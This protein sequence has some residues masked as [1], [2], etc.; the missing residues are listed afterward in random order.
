[1]REGHAPGP[2]GPREYDHC[3]E[4]EKAQQS[5]QALEGGSGPHPD[6]SHSQPTFLASGARTT[7]WAATAVPIDL[8]HT[9]GSVGTGRGLALINICKESGCILR[10]V[11]PTWGP[12][13]GR[14]GEGR[15]KVVPQAT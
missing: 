9:R 4:K 15:R 11:H 13:C 2:A 8:I 14:D 12:V 10:G 6:H 7:W 1:M 3:G 5:I